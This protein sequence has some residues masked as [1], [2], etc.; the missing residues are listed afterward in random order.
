MSANT[1]PTGSLETGRR[2][3]FLLFFD[4][5]A[6]T[7][8]AC[9]GLVLETHTLLVRFGHGFL[10]N[11]FAFDGLELGLEV[12][13]GFSVG[14]GVGAAAG[15]SHVDIVDVFDFVASVAPVD[16]LAIESNGIA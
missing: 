4:A 15:V 2:D 6:R 10:E 14:G 16:R 9:C 7:V 5:V 8:A 1:S 11:R 12:F 3:L 13:G